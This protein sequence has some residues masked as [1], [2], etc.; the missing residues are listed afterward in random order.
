MLLPQAAA[1][2]EQGQLDGL[3][4]GAQ[5]YVSRG[6]QPLVDQAWGYARPG[7]PLTTNSLMLWLSAGKPLTAVAIMQQVERHAC[8]LDDP[9]ALHLPEFAAG[10][11]EA[12]T[13][14]H[15]LT[16]TGGFRTV[17]TGWPEASWDEIIAAICCTPLEPNWVPGH[18][19]GYHPY[20]S[21]Y[22]LG[23]LVQRLSR[24]VLSD[25]VRSEICEPIGMHDTWLGMDRVRYRE[26]GDRIGRM[27]N[28][29]RP[30]LPPHQWASEEG[31]MHGSPGGGAYGPI[32]ELGYFYEALSRGGQRATGRILSPESVAALIGPQ[33]VGLVD[34]TFKQKIDWGLGVI[35]DS[36]RYNYPVSLYGYGRHASPRT[37]G[38]SGS[39][40]SVGMCDPEH[41]LVIALVFNGMAGEARHQRRVRAVLDAIYTDLELVPN[42]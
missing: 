21:W 20:T 41:D 10:G 19:A 6:C 8:R 40:S 36:K 12:I 42:P 4:I 29:E 5:L 15:L 14:R 9:V 34:E 16:H 32:R 11:K 17:D 37:F 38:H 39:Q 30:G 31:V 35:L 1:L 22:I 26:Y 2:I 28:T 27:Q 18:T 23:E 13:I 3:H 24:R 7:V 25:Y 33:R